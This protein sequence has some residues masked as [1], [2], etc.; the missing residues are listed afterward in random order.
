MNGHAVY[1]C[2]MELSHMYPSVIPN[3]IN[4]VFLGIVAHC[5]HGMAKSSPTVGG[6]GHVERNI[7]IELHR[8]SIAI[9]GQ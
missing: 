2:G 8:K 6:L 3:S 7:I 4:C 5:S 9:L 1:C